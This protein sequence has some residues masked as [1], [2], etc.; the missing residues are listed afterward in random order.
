MQDD[1]DLTEDAAGDG[2]GV[3][4]PPPP[5]STPRR[6]IIGGRTATAAVAGGLVVG[7]ITGGYVIS[8]AATASPSG[9]ATPSASAPGHGRAGWGPAART[10]DMQQAATA[11]GISASQLQTE[12]SAGKTIAGVAKE[13]NVAVDAVISTL[14]ADENAEIDAAVS[15]GHLTQAQAAQM[16]TQTTQRV[17]ALVNGT[18]PAHGPGSPRGA[19][20]LQGEDAAIAAG[21]IGVTTTQLQ[22]ELSA[23]KT[24]AAVAREHGVAAGTVI[25]AWAASEN[26]EIDARVSSGQITAAQGAQM[27]AQTTQRVTA[28][29][30]GTRPAGG[31][32]GPWGG[33]PPPG[34]PGGS[35]SAPTN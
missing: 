23:G 1:H 19:D 33:G 17:S 30:N 29:V 8:Q 22:T 10:Q 4:P 3:T 24:I 34:A 25:S 7:G 35:G 28:E 6:R 2:A 18:A 13:H 15:G 5:L 11:I 21:A 32:R 12:L 9:S 27:K 20:G 14:V 31:P 16:K 26:A